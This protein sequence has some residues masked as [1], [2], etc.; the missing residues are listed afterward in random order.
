[1]RVAV[2]GRALRPGAAHQRGVARYLRCLLEALASGGPED[3]YL[4]VVAGAEKPSPFSAPN[5]RLVRSRV[6]GRVTFGLAAVLG[7]PRLDRL[8][9]GCDVA[10]APAPAPLA[11]S[12]G[13]PLLLTVHDLSFEHPGDF[14][15]YERLWHRMARPGRLA[16]RARRVICPSGP[17]RDAVLARW[18][19]DPER[20]RVVLSG[21]GKVADAGAAAAGQP[22][23]AAAAAGQPQTAAASQPRT[24][25]A[26]P[27]GAALPPELAQPYVLAVGALEP[28]KLPGVLVEAHA[29]ARSRGLRAGLVF[30]GEGPLRGE[31]E[32]SHATVLGHVPDD[33]LEALYS[34]AL[35][36]ACVSR[37]EGFGFTPVEA[38]TRGTPV[39]VS[40][41][42][43][44]RETL[45]DGAI[46]VPSGNAEA[47][48]DAL[49]RLESEPGLRE[50]LVTAGREAVAELSWERAARETR[51]ILAEA[52]A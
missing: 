3:E 16:R 38:L 26:G 40:D 10:W 36:L 45:G 21:A 24:A 7:R 9:G 20:V 32:R 12:A 31:L 35:A 43:V 30:A 6:P 44:F 27:P 25:G 22:G 17:V 8:A 46:F 33:V 28:R 2:D 39:V 4:V 49:L 5:V 29:L 11:L 23:A 14:T 18:G 47:L 13:V 41:L 48:A 37:D 15:R 42:P 19:L 1:V 52:A 50:R 34:G 51:A